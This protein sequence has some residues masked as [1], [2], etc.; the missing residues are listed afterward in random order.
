MYVVPKYK[1]EYDRAGCIGAAS[2]AAVNPDWEIKEDGKASVKGGKKVEGK[3]AEE[4]EIEEK[5]LEKHKLAAEAC[6]VRV[7]KIKNLETGEY[8]AP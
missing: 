4:L 2:C 6:P 3:D 7:I 1:I 5:D 8:I